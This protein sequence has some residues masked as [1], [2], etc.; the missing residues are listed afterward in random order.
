M[1][2]ASLR[3]T[4]FLAPA[5]PAVLLSSEASAPD[6]TAAQDPSI[7]IRDGLIDGQFHACP[8]FV[9]DLGIFDVDIPDP[10][11]ALVDQSRTTRFRSASGRVTQSYFAWEDYPDVHDSHDVVMEFRVDPVPDPAH[12]DLPIL[13]NAGIDHDGDQPAQSDGLTANVN[14]APDTLHVEWEGGILAN[15]YTGDGRFFPKWAWPSVGDRVWVN[16]YWIFDC[17]HPRKL[18]FTEAELETCRLRILT[19]G[20]QYVYPRDCQVVTPKRGQPTEIHPIRAIASMRQQVATPPDSTGPIPV[21]ATDLH[22]HGRAGVVTDLLECGGGVILDDRTCGTRSG[23]TPVGCDTDNPAYPC[24]DI[25]LDHLGVPIAED[26]EFDICTPPRPSPGLLLT[27]WWEAGPG[28]TVPGRPPILQAV[29]VDDPLVDPCNSPEYGPEKIHVTIPL[30]GSGVTPDSV[31]ARR[32]YAGWTAPSRMRRFRVTLDQMRL[33]DDNDGAIWKYTSELTG[34]DDDCEC[35]FFWMNVDRAPSEWIRLSDHTSGNMD[36]YRGDPQNGGPMDFAGA[37]FDFQL[38]DGQPFTIRANGFD[39]GPSEGAWEPGQDCLDDHVAHHD[40]G[41]HVPFDYCFAKLATDSG[42]P[43]QDPFKDLTATF[44]PDNGYGV[45][46]RVLPSAPTEVRVLEYRPPLGYVPIDVVM[47]EYELVVTIEELPA[48][49]DGDGLLDT[50]ETTG[51]NPT[52]PLDADTDG[53]GLQ[54]GEEDADHDGGMDPGET[55]PNDP[56]TEDDGL[57][58]GCEVNGSNATDPLDPDTD[59]DGLTDGAEDADR[60]CARD[61]GE[62]DP[63]D[64]D[65]DDDDLGDGLEVDAGTDPLDADSDGDGIPDGEDVEFIQNIVSGLPVT[66]FKGAGNQTAMLALLDAIERR[67]AGGDTAQALNLLGTLRL[68]VDG[69][70]TAADGNDWIEECAAQVRVRSLIDLLVANLSG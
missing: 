56:D 67:I 47:S 14:Y 24:H 36:D 11:W 16:G 60:D 54:D 2:A 8:D 43:N 51:T 52:N 35:S 12:P 38:R 65:S 3:W 39:G 58:D 64:P 37:V 23:R 20:P 13:S 40:F 49:S 33:Y 44:G 42:S 30:A 31:Y 45:G 10:A 50:T 28:D 5:L 21:T 32:I 25:A 18:P 57:L 4:I 19:L 7:V 27:K 53:D 48:D 63:T 34:D 9:L 69:C 17:G 62:T 26:F 68:R 15:Q 70:G 59:D 1:F 6:R 55:N 61:A 41:D 22:I 29:P 66:V 46:T